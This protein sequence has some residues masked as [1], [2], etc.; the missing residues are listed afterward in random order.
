MV[1]PAS[2]ES[3]LVA[4]IMKKEQNCGF[5]ALFLPR[6]INANTHPKISRNQGSY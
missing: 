2:P 1:V 3:G 6:F 4:K 5:V